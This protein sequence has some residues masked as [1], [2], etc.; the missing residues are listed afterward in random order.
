MFIYKEKH[1]INKFFNKIIY[2]GHNAMYLNT[3]NYMYKASFIL[4]FFSKVVMSLKASFDHMMD[5]HF[6]GFL[7]NIILYLI[8]KCMIMLSPTGPIDKTVIL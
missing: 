8:C 2:L 6:H 4:I 7:V 5:R 1:K 3:N